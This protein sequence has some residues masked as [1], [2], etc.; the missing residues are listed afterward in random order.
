MIRICQC[1]VSVSPI[2]ARGIRRMKEMQWDA[3]GCN[4]MNGLDGY[5]MDTDGYSLTLEGWMDTYEEI[6]RFGK[7]P[8]CLPDCLY[9]ISNKQ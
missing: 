7:S 2:C 5:S 6:E 8:S 9:F 3:V 4:G 1:P